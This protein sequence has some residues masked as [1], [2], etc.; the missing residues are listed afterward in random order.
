VEFLSGTAIW[1]DL[2]RLI[3]EADQCRAA[4][5]YAGRHAPQLVP[6]GRGDFVIVDG[7]DEALERGSTHPDA[8]AEWLQAGVQVRSLPDLHAKVILLSS[9]AA[10]TAIIGSANASQHSNDVLLEAAVVTDDP[11]ACAAL[12]RQLDLWTPASVSELVDR[13]WLDRARRIYREPR[14]SRR[15]RRPLRFRADRTATLWLGTIQSTNAALSV[16]TQAVF[17]QAV[18]R[19][20]QVGEVEWWQLEPGDEALVLQG[21]NVVLIN[22]PSG[23]EQPAGQATAWG[24]AEIVRVVPGDDRHKP[25]AILVRES[26]LPTLRFSHVREAAGD[27][28]DWLQ[29]LARD[30]AAR[31][32]PLWP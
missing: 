1:D 19:Y 21:Q 4:I 9:G 15:P 30:A 13:V 17:E 26:G 16:A 2:R 27:Q 10:D 20:D 24:P 14:P 31:V 28:L 3:T 6:L 18:R 12:S 7:S 25:V 32:Y 5:A 29:P 8:L 23:R 11:K 22:N